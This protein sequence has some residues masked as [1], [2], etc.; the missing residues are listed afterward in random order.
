MAHAAV[1]GDGILSTEAS[2]SSFDRI[3]GAERVITFDGVLGTQGSLVVERCMT[4]TIAIVPKQKQYRMS[5][6][7]I[8]AV[9]FFCYSIG[10]QTM[11]KPN[12]NLRICTNMLHSYTTFLLQY[13]IEQYTDVLHN[14]RYYIYMVMN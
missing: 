10:D 9:F 5:I 8:N 4:V 13:Y 1:T 11:N 12:M 14:L 3:S 6:L 2:G 7:K